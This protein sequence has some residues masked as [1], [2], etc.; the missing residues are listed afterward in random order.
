M[1]NKISKFEKIYQQA[2][3]HKGETELKALLPT[4]IKTPK[5][6]AKITDDRYLAEMTKSIFKAGFVW[7]VIDNKWPNFE[8]AF[9]QFDI[10]TCCHLSPEKIDQ[11]CADAT[12]VRN[13]QKIL[14]VPNN[15]AMIAETARL[16]DSFASYIA[17]WPDE[18]YIGLLDHL[19]KHGDRMGG[20]SCQY[21]LRFM[22]KDGFLMTNDVNRALI[23]AGVI[24]KPATSK[25][26][27]KAVQEAF[28]LWK[29]ET[30]LSFASMSRILAL[31]IG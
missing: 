7:R 23:N 16:H 20:N 4:G 9:Y 15:A 29:E 30:G 8:R 24:D 27:R 5:Q 31:S 28:N 18:D 11:L 21:F 6:L 3:I 17:N 12:I 10:D 22:G 25:G 1:P 2:I 26:A 13:R 14:T 19:K